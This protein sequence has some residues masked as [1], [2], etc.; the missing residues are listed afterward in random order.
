MKKNYLL[1]LALLF[2][3]CLIAQSIQIPDSNFKAQLLAANTNTYIALGMA[4]SPIRIDTNLNGQIEASE[5][6]AVKKLDITDRNI[7]DLTGILAFQNLQE[8]RCERNQLTALDLVA[9]ANL[10]NLYC[11]INP[12][13]NLT[14]AGNSSIELIF[15]SNCQ[16]TNLDLS[17]MPALQHFDCQSNQISNLTLDNLPSLTS[18]MCTRNQLTSLHTAGMPNVAEIAC[19]SNP[20]SELDFSANPVIWSISLSNNPQL[21]SLN[22]KNNFQ[23]TELGLSVYPLLQSVCVDESES[24]YIQMLFNMSG[25]SIAVDANC[26]LESETFQDLANIVLFLNPANETL[27]VQTGELFET[28]ELY[29]SAG[30]RIRQFVGVQKLTNINVSDLQAGLYFLK[31]NFPNGQFTKKFLKK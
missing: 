8:L 28:I 23:Q 24:A 18:M 30:Q 6:L 20:I 15:C 4:N 10:K 1:I 2:G 5:A 7:S 22:L 21:V 13:T 17:N 27:T 31:I 29:D 19:D 16:L 12:L 11:S 26:A 25:N 9:M 14:V 3:N